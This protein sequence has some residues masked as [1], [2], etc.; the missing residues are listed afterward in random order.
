MLIARRF[1]WIASKNRESIMPAYLISN[2][3]VRDPEAF[4]TYRTRA[5]ASIQAFG[6]RYLVRGGEIDV[7]E[8]QPHPSALVIVEFPDTMTAKRWYASPE[9]AAALEVR[10]RALVRSLILVNGVNVS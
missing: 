6:G 7:L 2:V 1:A 3:T 4:E 9:Y 5:A 8:G 10:G